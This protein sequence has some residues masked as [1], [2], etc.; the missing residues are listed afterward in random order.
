MKLIKFPHYPSY[1]CWNKNKSLDTLPDINVLSYKVDIIRANVIR[2]QSYHK[3]CTY[4]NQPYPC[5]KREIPLSPY[6]PYLLLFIL[7]VRSTMT[8][9]RLPARQETLIVQLNPTL[10]GYGIGID[11]LSHPTSGHVVITN[12]EYNSP[13]YL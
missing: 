4:S 7:L 6:S 8:L 12:I 11:S 9:Q 2:L 13:A 10:D 3:Y 5:I 1:E